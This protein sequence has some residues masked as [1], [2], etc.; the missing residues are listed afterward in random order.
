M[1][2]FLKFLTELTPAEKR[3]GQLGWMDDE[4]N[5]HNTHVNYKT[6]PSEQLPKQDLDNIYAYVNRDA[7]PRGNIA[8]SLDKLVS[9]SSPINRTILSYRGIMLP[10]NTAAAIQ[11]SI[12][13]GHPY[14]FTS[15]WP[16]SWSNSQ[17]VAWDFVKPKGYRHTANDEQTSVIFE[18]V[19]PAG[20]KIARLN[21]SFGVGLEHVLPSHTKIKL[22]KIRSYRTGVVLSGS[23]VP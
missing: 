13:D 15:K 18:V 22:T 5:Y 7:K 20:T 11:K 3:Q 12:E 9:I 23:V 17:S 19:I 2:K 21:L 10:A 1:G 16:S 6:E 4:L 14:S 8:K